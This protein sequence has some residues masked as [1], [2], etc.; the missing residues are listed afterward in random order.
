M[1]VGYGRQVLR[2]L[3]ASG[4]YGRN[5]HGIAA[6]VRSVGMCRREYDEWWLVVSRSGV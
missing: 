1:I 2:I 4:L 6:P 3:D 5:S